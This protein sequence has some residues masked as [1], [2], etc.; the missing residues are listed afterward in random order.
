MI[1]AGDRMNYSAGNAYDHLYEAECGDAVRSLLLYGHI[2]DAKKMIGPLL[3]FDRKATRFHVAG[4]KLQLLAYYYWLSRDKK[5]MEESRAKWE[6]V[7]NFIRTNRKTENG[8]LPKDNYAG[9][10][11]TQVYSLNSNANCWRGLRDLAAVLDDIGDKTL[12]AELKKEAEEFRKVILVAV[13]K[14][15]N[16]EKKFV[17]VSLLGDEPA[18]DPLTA[19][20]M[21]SYYNLIIPYVLCSGIL[22][23]ELDGTVIDYLR[24]H[25]GLAMGMIRSTPHQGEFDNQPGVNP[26]YGLRYNLAILNRG[27]REHALVS[28]YGHLAQGMTRDTF[29]GGEG[30]RFLHGDK[31][32]RSFY[33]PPNSASNA[34]F[35]TTLRY[36]LIQDWDLNNDGVPETL[37]LCDAIPPRWLADGA[38]LKVENAPSA[39]GEVSF[40]VES[41][42]KKGEITV[43]VQSPPRVIEKWQ[44]R[45]PDPPGYEI[46]GI[47]IGHDELKRDA[48]GRVDLTGC[49]GKFEMRFALKPR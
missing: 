19:T 5:Y 10:V 25:G 13:A 15:I 12:A 28:F 31:Q 43:E 48:D 23:D 32:G 47:K 17:P 1:T 14:S 37:R 38:V 49:K 35:L 44:L 9:D 34:A 36:L 30:S 4:H 21:G 6:A 42:L 18:H 2:D 39:F 22:G 41:N 3:D 45:L 33:L 29:I 8:L 26:L 24:Q 7:A 11:N 27:D 20:R 40:K 46:T 16:K